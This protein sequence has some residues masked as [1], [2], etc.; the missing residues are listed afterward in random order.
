MG[1][2]GVWHVDLPGSGIVLVSPALADRF[3]TTGPSG[4]P[5]TLF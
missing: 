2:V 4:K 1:L 5:V 3:F